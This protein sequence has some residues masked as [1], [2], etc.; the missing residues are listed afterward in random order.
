MKRVTPITKQCKK[1]EASFSLPPWL[2]KVSNF[3]SKDC[4]YSFLNKKQSRMRDCITCKSVFEKTSAT[5]GKFCSKECYWNSKTRRKD[6]KCESC[7]QV[8]SPVKGV[9]FCRACMGAQN[10]G[11]NHPRWIVDR[12]QLA[13]R[14]V[15]NDSAYREWRK[16]VWLR[17]NFACKIANPDCVGRIEAHHILVWKDYPELRYEVNNGITLCHFHHPRKRNDEIRLSPYFQELV[18]LSTPL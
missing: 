13:K 10:T 9:R 6:Y 3:C 15:R 8:I 11:V 16:Q 5:T 2:A 18:K 14:Q 7:T 12:S 4:R 17:D 1:C